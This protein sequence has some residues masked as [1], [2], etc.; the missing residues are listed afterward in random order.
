[1][2]GFVEDSGDEE[3]RLGFGGEGVMVS[4]WDC[5]ALGLVC[6]VGGVRVESMEGFSRVL[7]GNGWSLFRSRKGD[8]GGGVEENGRLGAVFLFRKV[9]AGRVRRWNGERDGEGKC[10]VRE[11]RLPGLDFKNVPLRILQYIVLMTDDVFY[12][13]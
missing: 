5:C 9:E 10:R 13:A 1:M 8:G 2:L 12:L 11:L 3:G 7:A 6:R 4:S